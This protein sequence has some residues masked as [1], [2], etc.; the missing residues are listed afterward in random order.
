MKIAVVLAVYNC[1]K[2]IDLAIESIFVQTRIP[3]EVVVVDDG[4]T[5]GTLDV[6]SKCRRPI[7]VL[8]QPHRG[9]P[10]ALNFGVA[11]TSADLLSF[12][13]ADDLWLPEK[14]ERQ[15]DWLVANPTFDAVFGL[16]RQFVSPDVGNARPFEPQAG[17]CKDAMMIRRAAFDGI[18]PFDETMAVADFVEWYSRATGQDFQ[19]RMLEEVFAL[20]RLHRSNTGF[21][22][23]EGQQEETLLALKRMLDLRRRRAPKTDTASVVG[24]A[25]HSFGGDYEE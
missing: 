14:T 2:Y 12:L 24:A 16:I 8:T 25:S 22:Q 21:V 7:R 4:S 19:W 13:D 6:L 11:N 15:H 10:T 5:D 18:G 3:D 1:A 20:R 17:L 23:R 9:A